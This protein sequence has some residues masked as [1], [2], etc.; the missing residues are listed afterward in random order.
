MS[1][2]VGLI[3]EP[4]SH[5]STETHEERIRSR[6]Q[7]LFG[8]PPSGGLLIRGIRLKG[9]TQ[10][11]Q[12]WYCRSIAS[13]LLTRLRWRSSVISVESQARTISRMSA[14]EMVL[15]PSV[16]TFASLCSR[17]LRATSTE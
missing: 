1:V 3:A 10:N 2:D 9:E 13:I 17:E 14:V 16:S 6:A 8:A 15:L 11:S 5:F 4:Q 7:Q 12:R